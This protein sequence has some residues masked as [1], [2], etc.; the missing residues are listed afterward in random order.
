MNNQ[1]Q[2]DIVTGLSNLSNPSEEPKKT[3]E[4][5]CN[6]NFV[7]KVEKLNDDFTSWAVGSTLDNPSCV[8][9]PVFKDYENHLK[10]LQAEKNL[11]MK[12]I[13]LNNEFSEWIK[14]NVEENP[15]C[16]L[17]PTF[18]D[19]VTQLEMLRGCLK[20]VMKTQKGVPTLIK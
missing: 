12:V 2:S 15:L 8:L 11:K 7:A 17:S 6:Q 4:L 10:L 1:K 20:N 3:H 19:Y 5:K 16:H 13:K 14:K 9:T 18:N